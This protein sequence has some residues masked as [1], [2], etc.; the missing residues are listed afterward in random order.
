MAADK[1]YGKIIHGDK[2]AGRIIESDKVV[3]GG[4]DLSKPPSGFKQEDWDKL[5]NATRL[6]LKDFANRNK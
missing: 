6:W 4:V 1:V 3:V 5:D 2:V